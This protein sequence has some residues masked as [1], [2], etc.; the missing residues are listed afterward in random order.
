MNIKPKSID[1]DPIN[2]IMYVRF[3]DGMTHKTIEY[4]P[5]EVL[6][7]LSRRGVLLGIE[8]LNLSVPRN[9][10]NELSKEYHNPAIKKIH[11][12]EAQKIFA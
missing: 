10:L 1:I 7:D 8:F 12:L 9:I 2:K 5:E 6:L 3:Q 4:K 11:P